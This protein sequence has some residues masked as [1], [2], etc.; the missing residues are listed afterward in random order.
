MS[1]SKESRRCYRG[2]ACDTQHVLTK[3][4]SGLLVKTKCL[5]RSFR[6]DQ[7]E[8]EFENDVAEP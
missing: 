7:S 6:V 8:L 4:L 2:A 1:F 3:S 5:S